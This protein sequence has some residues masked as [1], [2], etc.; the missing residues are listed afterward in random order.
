MRRQRRRSPVHRIRTDP[1]ALSSPRK[2]SARRSIQHRAQALDRGGDRGRL[3]REAQPQ[4]ALAHRPEGAAGR[5]PDL[6]AGA[7]A[8]WRR[9]GCRSPRRRAGRHRT[10]PLGRAT[11][12]R[13]TASAAHRS[14][15]RARRGSAPQSSRT[16]G[17]PS[18]IA[19]MPARCRKVGEP[20]V[21]NSISFSI[22][23]SRSGGIT[24]QPSRQPV[25][26]QVF[27]KLLTTISRS[28]GSRG[29]E[30]RRRHLVAI[31]DAVIDLVGDDPQPAPA[32]EI[33]QR[34]DLVGRCR[35]AGR[36]GRRVDEDP[37]GARVARGDELS[38]SS[39][40]PPP[41]AG[42][43]ETRRGSPPMIETT[44]AM[45]GQIGATMTRLSPGSIS[46]CAIEHQR[47]DA[48]A[49][50]DDALHADGPRIQPAQIV[51]DRLAQLGQAGLVGVE[52]LAGA[53][54][55]GGRLADKAG[56]GTIA[57]AVPQRDDIRIAHAERGNLG[58]PRGRQVE[59]RMGARTA[60]S[61]HCRPGASRDPFSGRR[62][63]TRWVP[64][65]AGTTPGQPSAGRDGVIA[66]V[67]PRIPAATLRA[68]ARAASCRHSP[69]RS[70]RR[71]D[72]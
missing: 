54:R 61:F 67:L 29:H 60:R 49:G 62:M 51:G 17:S 52:G 24:T 14:P 43:S 47:V 40:Q 50:D 69:C 44:A 46:A 45:F 35:P 21:L 33:G 3:A 26:A 58:D 37:L 63:L 34:R 31:D 41:G 70:G 11:S 9:R 53:H 66:S 23:G 10:R 8:P 4:I 30:K 71:R 18:R 57:L 5:Q 32:R 7:G 27:E 39:R 68:P 59:D 12:T 19:A 56:V 15:P 36:V 25:I 48:G 28:S 13:R 1:E 20:L 72:R 55:R 2:R 38:R 65:C 6:G 42:S 64:A 22:V 16:N